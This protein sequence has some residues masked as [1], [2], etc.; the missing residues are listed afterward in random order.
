MLVKNDPIQK[1]KLVMNKNVII[2]FFIR[3]KQT[4]SEKCLVKYRTKR[5]LKIKIKWK[6][7][8]Q[9]YSQEK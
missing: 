1:K 6:Q 4:S 9:N 7:G 2:T 3:G 8:L 5:I